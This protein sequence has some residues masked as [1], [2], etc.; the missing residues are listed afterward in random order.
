MRRTLGAT[1][2]EPAAPQPAPQGSVPPAYPPAA[3]PEGYAPHPSSQGHP[4][5]VPQHP[6]RHQ[7]AAPQAY[8]H[9]HPAQE[10]APQPQPQAQP[11][12][13]AIASSFVTEKEHP[14]CP[15]PFTVQIGDDKMEGTGLSLTH[16]YVRVPVSPDEGLIGTRHLASIQFQFEGFQLDLTPEVI[17]ARG[18]EH[19]EVA[20]E[21]ADPTGAHLPQLRYVI[22]SFIA[23]DF[24]TL[25]AFLSYT[26]PVKPKSPKAQAGEK[27]RNYVKSLG[28]I[29]V[30]LMLIAVAL[31]IVMQRY[32]H[33]Y[34]PRPVFI[35]QAGQELRSTS[36]GQI[37]YL[38]P[39]AGEGEVIYS[40]SANSGD[41]LNFQLPCDCTITLADGVFEGATVL[42]SDPVLSFHQRGE[43]RVQVE[44]MMSV[45]GLS[46]AVNGENV[47]IVMSDGRVLPVKVIQSSAT[48][49][50][51]QNGDLYLP[52]RLQAPQG[53]L[54]SEDI[55]KPARVRLTRTL[56]FLKKFKEE[57]PAWAL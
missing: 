20:L 47:S 6:H 56:P 48:N 28:V 3:S 31:N 37:T 51:A 41:I 4:H 44:A 16:A 26:G 7:Q 40:I 54:T 46:R 30:S 45:E 55:G 14:I 43:T 32:I 33:S 12:Q 53:V 52:V 2:V 21:F 50:A 29:L 27:K 49:A 19:G 22:N 38:N 57:A 13:P 35:A 24:V 17:I 23:G 36:A 18:R 9:P 5:A 10:A 11:A 15:I 39:E 1:R 8:A 25:G 42:P 34:E